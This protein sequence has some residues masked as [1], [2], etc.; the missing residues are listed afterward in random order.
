LT[1]CAGSLVYHAE[2]RLPSP[3]VVLWG[4]CRAWVSGIVRFASRQNGTTGAGGVP[5][6]AG[7]VPTADLIRRFQRG[8]PR[9][10]EALYDRFKDY[11]YRTA[12]F[13]TRNSGDAEEAVQ[14]TFMDVLRALPNYRVEGPARFETWLYRVTVNRCRSRMRRKTLPSADWDEIEERLERIPATHPNYDPEGV[15]L[16]RERAV[17][18]WQAVDRLPEGQRVVVLLRYQQGLSYGEIAQTLGIS[19]GTV[20]S[21]LYHAHRRLKEQ[22]QL[23]EEELA[24]TEV[25][26]E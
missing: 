7:G 16:H 24:G 6:A 5:T 20:K 15:A 3:F 21:R 11:V 10:F 14:E 26:V 2:W 17:A 25:K 19:D 1:V 12:F 8:Q 23:T 9:A 13:I 4:R 22:L 18:L